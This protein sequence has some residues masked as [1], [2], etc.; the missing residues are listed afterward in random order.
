VEFTFFLDKKAKL[1]TFKSH[2]MLRWRDVLSNYSE[3]I[4]HLLFRHPN[5]VYLT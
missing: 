4:S 1:A 5:I 3:H 2:F